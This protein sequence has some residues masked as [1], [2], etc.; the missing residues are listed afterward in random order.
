MT[1]K[2]SDPD[3]GGATPQGGA[4]RSAAILTLRDMV[5]TENGAGLGGGVC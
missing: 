3:P 4:I 5:I 2:N 1:L